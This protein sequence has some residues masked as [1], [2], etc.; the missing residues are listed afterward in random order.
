MICKVESGSGINHFGSTALKGGWG[1]GGVTTQ[2][3][4]WLEGGKNNTR[5]KE[6]CKYGYMP[7]R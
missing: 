2:V 1:A 4:G 7:I 6:I 5:F 3:A